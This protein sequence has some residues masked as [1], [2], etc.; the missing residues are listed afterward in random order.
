MMSP[1]RLAAWLRQ[2][3]HDIEYFV[4]V[5]LPTDDDPNKEKSIAQYPGY[6]EA[7]KDHVEFA[8]EVLEEIQSHADSTNQVNRYEVRALIKKEV[9]TSRI[10]R[11]IPSPA[12]SLPDP[13]DI[14]HGPAAANSSAQQLVRTIEALLRVN[15][16]SFGMIQNAWKDILATQAEQIESL[17]KRE[18]K[19]ADTVLVEISRQNEIDESDIN[20]TRALNKLT[21]MIEKYAPLVLSNLTG[22]EIPE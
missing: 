2:V 12:D 6:A 3:P 11:G 1:S 22:E 21:D 19:L 7:E 10:V 8:R 17:R 13:L 14:N 5:L 16:Q 9:M 20:K 18:S 15:V 4:I